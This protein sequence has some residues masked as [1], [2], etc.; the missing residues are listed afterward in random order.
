[1]ARHF[2]KGKCLD[3]N[4]KTTGMCIVGGNGNDAA[5]LEK[6]GKC[7]KL[8]NEHVA[9]ECHFKVTPMITENR[10]SDT[11]MPKFITFGKSS[12]IACST[13]SSTCSLLSLILLSLFFL[14]FLCKG[15]SPR[16]WGLQSLLSSP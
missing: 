16:P 2:L 5:T 10:D 1:M 14:F 3:E 15:S 7:A 12:A 13:K 11:C 6:F 4:V 9:Q 8:K